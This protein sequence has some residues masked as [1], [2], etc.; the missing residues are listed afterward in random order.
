MKT[1]A[2]RLAVLGFCMIGLMFANGC[3]K[4]NNLSIIDVPITVTLNPAV[5]NSALPYAAPP[6]CQDLT[7]NSKFND[8]KDKI[9]SGSISKLS[10]Q[11]FTYNGTPAAA[12]AMYDKIEYKLKFDP[13]YGDA[14]E[15][16]L[17]SFSNV[18]VATLMA[19]PQEIT[20]NN[21][22]LN[23][24]VAKI[25]DRPKFCIYS[26]YNLNGGVGTITTMNSELKITFQFKVDAL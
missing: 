1:L 18:S 8:N 10:F 20:V 16:L 5:T 12:T 21:A 17:G 26:T 2:T 23:T 25:K 9:K 4:I 6:E 3:D 24:A 15:Y 7:S 22:D 13:S 11:V 19:A 14:N